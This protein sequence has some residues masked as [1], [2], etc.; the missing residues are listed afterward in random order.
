MYKIARGS[1]RAI[2]R[3]P[4][5]GGPRRARAAG[6]VARSIGSFSFQEVPSALTLTDKSHPP[7]AAG[8]NHHQANPGAA[9]ATRP[10][11]GATNRCA[12]SNGNACTTAAVP[13]AAPAGCAASALQTTANSPDDRGN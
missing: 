11:Q 12:T 8:C 7:P 5:P 4:S 10:R 2:P 6:A 9:G 1:R 3:D 13:A